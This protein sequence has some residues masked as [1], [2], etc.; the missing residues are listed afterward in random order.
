MTEQLRLEQ[1]AY[2]EANPNQLAGLVDLMPELALDKEPTLE[3]ARELADTF[4][5]KDEFFDDPTRS[6]FFL[7]LSQRLVRARTSPD[8][9]PAQRVQEEGF[10]NMAVPLL[11]L[12]KSGKY[13]NVKDR[14]DQEPPPLPEVQRQIH[15][16]YTDSRLT[17]ELKTAIESGLLSD[18]KSRLGI[19]GNAQPFELRVIN[20]GDVYTASGMEPKRPKEDYDIPPSPD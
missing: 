14:I 6:L 7:M 16:K 12:D 19:N 5:L 8:Y 1:P 2:P 3:A 11:A 18:V 9:Q 15:D 17:S 13:P 4:A 10:V 20:V